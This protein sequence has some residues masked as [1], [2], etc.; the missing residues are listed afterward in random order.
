MSPS[1]RRSN[2]TTLSSYPTSLKRIRAVN[3]IRNVLLDASS[4]FKEC[5]ERLFVHKN[6]VKYRISKINE[7]L[8][9]DM[10]NAAEAYE[11]YLAMI[12][13]RLVTNE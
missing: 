11:V 2:P 6:T 10:T 3:D 7:A 8:G 1:R 9:Y 13:Y 4:D 5:G 12:L